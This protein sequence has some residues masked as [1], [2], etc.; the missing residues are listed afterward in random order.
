MFRKAISLA[1]LTLAFLG[2]AWAAALPANGRYVQHQ[3]G[4]Q[5]YTGI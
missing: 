3:V 1:V 5:K 2:A 4:E